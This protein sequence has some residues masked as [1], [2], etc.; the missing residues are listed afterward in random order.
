[1]SG[2]LSVLLGD[3]AAAGSSTPNPIAIFGSDL[4]AWYRADVGV[5]SNAGGTTPATNGSGVKNWQDQSG[6]G[7]HLLSIGAGD[8]TYNTTGFN[9]RK[10][11]TFVNGNGNA[12]RAL[13]VALSGGLFSAWIAANIT[14]SSNGVGR[15]YGY[16]SPTET[17]LGTN[18]A[19]IG[20][21]AGSTTSYGGFQGGV[22]FVSNGT[23]ANG[24]NYRLG[25]VFDTTGT[26]NGICYINN[27]ANASTNLSGV[28]VGF[29]T[30]G[31]ILVGDEATPT[32]AFDGVL[33][34]IIITKVVATSGQIN[35]VDDWLKSN[36]G[37]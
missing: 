9:G 8:P 20:V 31:A 32:A 6:N 16:A 35:A 10:T 37:L 14:S 34:E 25:T 3:N 18:S 23:I 2:V 21:L 4:V 5:F 26:H 17:M 7:Y 28:W 15:V 30:A 24:T 36:W 11:I 1:M 13:S 12:L 29:N 33:S 27:V 19:I 22:G